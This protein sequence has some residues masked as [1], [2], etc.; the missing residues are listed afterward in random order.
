MSETTD[1]LPDDTLRDSLFQLMHTIDAAG[2]VV[3]SGSE[4]ELLQSIVEAAARIFGAAAAS[5]A[6]VDE[7]QQRLVFHVAIGEGSD[8]LVGKSFPLN[9]GIAGYVVMT[10]QPMA[11]S[12]V[13]KDKRFNQ[14]FAQSTGYVPRS[15]LATPLVSK[16][17]VIG[18]M[19]V[20]DK[21]NAPAF[22]LQDI[23]LL[24][25]FANQ[26]AIAIHQS[27]Q[28]RQLGTVWVER[29]RQITPEAG[30]NQALSALESANQDEIPDDLRALAERI[31]AIS[32]LGSREM[33]L[34]LDV[35]KA[36]E[37]Y[38]RQSPGMKVARR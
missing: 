17:R 3:F 36:F 27:Q 26:A 11:I 4:K 32:R 23:E 25:L 10:G 12:D 1:Q 35:L 31:Q 34:C 15:I 37:V 8:T 28:M 29:L 5:I 14:G 24:G 16:E 13:L 22:G 30:T 9:Q 38:A 19:E 2:E 7:Q 6:L 33:Q 21:I 20:L 18:V